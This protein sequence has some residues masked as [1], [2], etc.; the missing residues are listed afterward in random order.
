MHTSIPQKKLSPLSKILVISIGRTGAATPVAVFDPVIVAGT[1][2]VQHASYIMP[3][4]LSVKTF[5]SILLLFIRQAT[6]FLVQKVLLELRPKSTKAFQYEAE[7]ARQ[8]LNS[9]IP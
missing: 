6:S 9:N 2:V 4:R 3:M 7:L 8:Y 5:V 1:T